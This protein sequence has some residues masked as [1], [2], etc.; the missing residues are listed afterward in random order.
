MK[1]L[2]KAISALLICLSFQAVVIAQTTEPKKFQGF[3]GTYHP[4]KGTAYGGNGWLEGE[5]IQK[6]FNF[7]ENAVISQAAYSGYDFT[8]NIENNCK[9]WD[10]NKLYGI[11]RPP[12]EKGVINQPK[13]TELLKPFQTEPGMIQGARRFSQISRRCPQLV[14]VIIDDFYN[15]Y[16]KLLTAEDL[17]DIKDALSGKSVDENGKVDRS[18]TATTPHLKLFI[19]VYEHQLDKILGKDMS[20]LVDGI[21]FWTWKQTEHH[22]N[23]D[24]YIETLQKNYPNK[25]IIAG[26]YVFNGAETPIPAS[27]HHLV[28]RVIDLYEHGRINGL[29]IFSA[30]WMSRERSARERWQE[31]AL[32]QFLGR[33]YYPFLGEA[34]GRV[35]GARSKE[36]ITNALVTV[37]RF[38]NGKPLLV[39]RKFTDRKGAYSFGSWAGRNKDE[40]V[41]YEI[42][43]E[44]DG[45]KPQT[46]RVKLR[47][48]ESIE[49]ADARLKK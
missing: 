48:G 22:K 30:V 11:L 4:F 24:S 32:P 35:V 18:S 36:P 6:A 34:V 19:V 25:E 43:I 39:A 17:R 15:D 41:G 46:L 26:V 10:I 1:R 33:V 38:A 49:S 12:T 9:N 40:R 47:A 7:G 28:E 8:E 16:P 13:D 20:D 45:F 21:S 2:L 14:G 27:V 42:R 3:L 44:S 31:L 29:L 23:F 5:L 37:T